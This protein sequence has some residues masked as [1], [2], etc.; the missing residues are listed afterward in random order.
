VLTV[1]EI[2]FLLGNVTHKPGWEFEIH[3]SE[4][5]GPFIRILIAVEDS[6]NPG[7]TVT[8]GINT[9]MPPIPD[10]DYLLT[11][12]RWRIDRIESHETR[13]FLKCNG[14]VVWD[15]HAEGEPYR[16]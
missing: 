15:P 10:K 12:L 3:E 13:E 5:E 4:F 16:V 1:Q 6:Y 9:F 7:E 11:W 2:R 14:E 8:L